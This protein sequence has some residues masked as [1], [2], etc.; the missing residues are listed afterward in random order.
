MCG[1]T[2]PLPVWNDLELGFRILLAGAKIAGI[3]EVLAVIYS[4][5]ESITGKSFTAKEGLW[6]RTLDEIR[7]ENLHHD[8]PL[9]TEINRII[10][11]REVILAAHYLKEGNRTGAKLLKKNS[12][13]DTSLK[14]KMILNL[15]YRYTARGGRGIWRIIKPFYL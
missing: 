2:K 6:E 5:E 9:K 14:D 15:A 13:S 4:Q 7:N 3:D 12:L 11:Y 10:K 1:W 8:H